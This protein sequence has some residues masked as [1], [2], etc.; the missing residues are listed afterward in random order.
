MSRKLALERQQAEPCERVVMKG[1]CSNITDENL[2]AFLQGLSLT[3]VVAPHGKRGWHAYSPGVGQPFTGTCASKR[4]AKEQVR[5]RFA[6]QVGEWEPCNPWGM[7][8]TDE[9]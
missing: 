1:L 8:G 2:R 9:S 3:I 4:T 6:E 7:L 5:R